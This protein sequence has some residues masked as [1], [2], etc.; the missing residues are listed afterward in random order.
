MAKV[1]LS[2]FLVFC[3]QMGSLDKLS[4]VTFCKKTGKKESKIIISVD[5]IQNISSNFHTK[6]CLDFKELHYFICK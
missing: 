4:L 5:E 3:E 1:G 2:V 6:F